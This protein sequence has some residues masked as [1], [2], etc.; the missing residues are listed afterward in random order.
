MAERKENISKVFSSFSFSFSFYIGAGLVPIAKKKNIPE[1]RP[2]LHGLEEIQPSFAKKKTPKSGRLGQG[3]ASWTGFFPPLH[4][5][6]FNNPQ[7]Q[8][9]SGRSHPLGLRWW[10]GHHQPALGG[11]FGPLESL[12]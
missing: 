9:G 7:G 1:I 2:D 11:G 10:S 3:G 8:V 6:G 12:E 4:G 5:G